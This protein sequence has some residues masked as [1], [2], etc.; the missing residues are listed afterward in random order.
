MLR[1]I[2]FYASLLSRDLGYQNKKGERVIASQGHVLV[3]G[4]VEAHAMGDRGC[5]AS[6]KTIGAETGLSAG[7]VANILSELNRAEWIDV[8]LDDKNQRTSIIPLMTLHAG[9]NPPSRE[10]ESPLHADVNID[11]NNKEQKETSAKANED[12]FYELVEQLG[13]TRGRVKFLPARQSKLAARLKNADAAA[14]RRAAVA[15]SR[16]PFHMGQ[17]ENN[18]KYGDIDFLLRNDEMIEKWSNHLSV[19]ET[20][21]GVAKV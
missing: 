9:V 12:L 4:A 18:R 17:N 5:I 20:M 11:N 8:K 15:L 21:N 14:L 3:Y 6:N 7:R 19:S 10:S 2:P 13:F 16:S 1:N